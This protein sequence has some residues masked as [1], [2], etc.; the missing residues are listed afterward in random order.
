MKI[1]NAIF[2][3]GLSSAK[4][5]IM[6]G[7]LAQSVRR[8]I[9]GDWVN[10][11][12]PRHRRDDI[13]GTKGFKPLAAMIL[14]MQGFNGDSADPEAHSTFQ[15]EMDNLEN[16]YTSYGCYCW[17]DGIGSGVIGGGRTKDMSDHHCKE[18]YRCYK[19]VNI[20]YAQNYTDI[21]YD[22][23]FKMGD[24]G[25]RQ[26]DCQINN[27]QDGEN[28]CECDKRFAANI[29][30]TEKSCKAGAAADPMF[31]EYC[32]DEQWR[33]TSGNVLGTTTEGPFNPHNDASCEKQH[34]G[35]DK[36]NCCGIYPNRYPY[37][38]KMKECCQEERTGADTNPVT[39]W[40]LYKSGECE[41]TPNG[42]IVESEEGN[43]HSYVA[44]GSN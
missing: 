12:I 3:L 27:K 30:A 4:P 43:P 15:A 41:E 7:K 21:D 37:D 6:G 18:L 38:K 5:S 10:K 39:T 40:S 35:H 20:D 13:D 2:L 42:I 36:D 29:A 26:L 19:C 24:N 14:Y 23:D 8:S 17:I 33:T 16:I 31:G 25:E 28:I 32:I 34:H 1:S 11:M 22:V 9:Q 44:I